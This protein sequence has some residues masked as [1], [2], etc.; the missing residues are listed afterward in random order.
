MATAS[1]TETINDFIRGIELRDVKLVE[2]SLK[3]K[4]SPD[5]P[6][7]SFHPLFYL[8]ATT[9]GQSGS[10]I[11]A[12]VTEDQYTKNT[13]A[14]I[15]LLFKYGAKVADPDQ[16]ATREYKTLMDR[17]VLSE[18]F[19]DSSTALLHAILET[20]ESKRPVY[21]PDIT[22][23]LNVM[24]LGAVQQGADV[25]IRGTVSNALN[26]LE[27]LHNVVRQRLENPQ[28][29]IEKEIAGK[30]AAAAAEYFAPFKRPTV[31]DVIKAAFPDGVPRPQQQ[32][33]GEESGMRGNFS[34]KASSEGVPLASFIRELPKRDP[35][36]V[37]KEMDEG[38]VGYDSQKKEAK[39]LTFR[40]QFTEALAENG[41]GAPA[42]KKLGAF[43]I[44]P[45]SIGKSTY[46]FK[47]SELLVALG[48]AGP[49]YVEFN[50]ENGAAA[51]ESLDVQALAKIF[52][53][54]NIINIELADINYDPRNPMSDFSLRMVSALKASML[55]RADKPVVFITGKAETIDE[56]L[57]SNPSLEA[58]APNFLRL[59]DMNV[60]T[61][62]KVLDQKLGKFTIESDA[63]QLVIKA[64]E[65]ARQELGKQF[66]SVKGVMR[67]VEALP[68]RMGERLFGPNS[69][70]NPSLAELTTVTAADI[71]GL[72]LFTL[73][74]GPAIAK[75]QPAGFN[76]R[77][78]YSS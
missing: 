28:T 8:L 59:N 36:E 71:K 49:K 27:R 16:Y 19:V 26:L 60:E 77:M 7:S 48:L 2:E 32:E 50:K 47:K 33:D 72:D 44:G 73:L 38:L 14:I 46:A 62:G 1:V 53:K 43:I 76:S 54:A 35:A 11:Q 57:E 67:V 29:D 52:S 20:A 6:V 70:G 65:E 78:R 64:M 31:P 9:Y 21:K 30:H 5:T 66:G 58:L 74:A 3:A 51:S 40:R 75:K 69:K 39:S 4:V 41:A 15:D 24:V 17:L 18:H 23:T 56:I 68:D 12:A 13:S 10:D 25:D 63:R 55:G 37:L 22:A 45:D 34:R 61:L 42:E